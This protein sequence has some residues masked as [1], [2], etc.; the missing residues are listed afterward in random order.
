M[1]A[2]RNTLTPI[3]FLLLCCMVLF[4][5]GCSRTMGFQSTGAVV[6]PK[7][8][9]Q[10]QYMLGINAYIAEDYGVAAEAFSTVVEHASDPVLARKALYGLACTR[11]MF[12]DTEEKLRLAMQ[13]WHG[14]LR[15]APRNWALENP[16]LFDPI[17][18]KEFFIQNKGHDAAHHG[19]EAGAEPPASWSE[20]GLQDELAKLKTQ[21]NAA[22][23]AALQR[24]GAIRALE[25][26]NAKLKE[27]IRAIEQIDR[28]I[29]EKKTAIPSNE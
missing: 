3:A 15:T 7:N 27:Q 23:Q 12:A 4:G 16:L 2:K 11:F 25:E 19:V 20:N 13:D 22:K 17:I 24:Q 6:A 8:V 10:D 26:E 14:W 1:S 21:L 9:F 18:D 28:K 29:Q 5:A